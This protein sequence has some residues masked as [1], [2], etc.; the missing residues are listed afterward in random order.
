MKSLSNGRLFYL[1]N[2][3]DKDMDIK[4]IESPQ[5]G[6]FKE[7]VKKQQP[8]KAR[9]EG[10]FTVEGLR[11]VDEVLRSLDEKSGLPAWETESIWVSESFAGSNR[12]YMA[13]LEKTELRVYRIPDAMFGRL[14]DT[15]H[16]QGVL[17]IVRRRKVTPE[18][19]FTKKSGQLIVILENLQDPGNVGT[20]LRTADAAGATAILLTKGTADV[21]SPKVVRSSMGSLLHI[22]VLA[23][24]SVAAV[25]P[26][27]KK[28]EIPLLAAH[29]DG[30]KAPWE[31]DITRSVALMIG[32]EGAGLSE[33]AAGLAD[34][35][36]KIPMP[37]HAESLNAGIAAGM[38][39]YEVTRQ[40]SFIDP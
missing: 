26:A 33:E 18:E 30:T 32:N 27:L 31:I 16:P 28:L 8:Q 38:L 5:N 20:I 37:G 1:F 24:P 25:A 29:L 12:G 14:S 9:Q 34:E 13:S 10:V 2:V 19:V 15:E 17:A 21:Y 6:T 4:I 39:L 7:A 11:A 23:I 35:L 3:Q 22:P 40:R 36:V